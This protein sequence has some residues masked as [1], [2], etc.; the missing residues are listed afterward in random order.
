MQAKEVVYF[1]WDN[2]SG[3]TKIGKTNDLARRMK[4]IQAMSPVILTLRYRMLVDPADVFSIERYF[5]TLFRAQR[6]HGEWFDLDDKDLIAVREYSDMLRTRRLTGM[7]RDWS[8]VVKSALKVFAV[9]TIHVLLLH[10][11]LAIIP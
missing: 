4:N 7:A 5:H 10:E 2:S 1:I 6:K 3:L 9:F 8:P 11:I